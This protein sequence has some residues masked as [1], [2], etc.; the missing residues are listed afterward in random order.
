MELAFVTT[1]RH[2]VVQAQKVFS[3][4]GIT[5]KQIDESYDESSDDTNVEIVRKAS[6]ILAEKKGFPLFVEDTSI[7]FEAYPGFRLRDK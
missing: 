7:F 6:K 2:K 3:S 4:F 5:I 1:N